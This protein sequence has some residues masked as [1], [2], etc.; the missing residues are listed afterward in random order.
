MLR[1]HCVK[2]LNAV[3]QRVIGSRELHKL[4]GMNTETVLADWD[5]P[6]EG[7][8]L[9]TRHGTEL[10]TDLK[11]DLTLA[12]EHFVVREIPL[13]NEGAPVGFKT[14]LC[15]YLLPHS[16][17]HD[18]NT[19]PYV[20]LTLHKTKMETDTC[21]RHMAETAKCDP[22]LI[23]YAGRKDKGADTMQY[24]TIPQVQFQNLFFASRRGET[25][26]FELGDPTGAHAPLTW[27]ALEGNWF[28]LTFVG[29][30]RIIGH[31]KHDE[32]LK[33]IR[34]NGFV[35][36]FGLQRFGSPRFNSPI[37][38]RYLDQG[39]PLEAVVCMLIGLCPKGRDWTRLKL[40][41]GAIRAVYDSLGSGLE[42]H[43]MR[44]LL[45]AAEKQSS[46]DVDW[47][48]AISQSQR[49]TYVHSWHS[50][51]WNYVA[52]FRVS[53]LGVNPIAGDL[54]I[55]GPGGSVHH[56]PPHV[57]DGGKTDVSGRH[58]CLPLPITGSLKPKNKAGK[59]IDNVLDELKVSSMNGGYGPA[60]EARELLIRPINLQWHRPQKDSLVLTFSLPP[61]CFATALVREWLG[62]NFYHPVDGDGP[63]IPSDCEEE[64]RVV[65]ERM[66]RI[67]DDFV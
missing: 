43:Y 14:N 60:K 40:K 2:R 9:W 22:A 24:I 55:N 21:V 37:V 52:Q 49:S 48:K 38:G 47:K 19:S 63:L 45:T 29:D 7:N 8:L 10:Q 66:A 18:V 32:A 1:V 39:D 41:D 54:V 3:P 20:R 36:F 51:L 35:N 62:H 30:P 58:V 26:P 31:A 64:L 4:L 16:L 11:A 65:W 13:G 25:L 28:Q 6:F 56:F 57:W 44:L 17:G 59:F 5:R 15:E 61:G 42:A 67:R 23:T 34:D 53:E 12:P 50:L 27:G 33:R 46:K